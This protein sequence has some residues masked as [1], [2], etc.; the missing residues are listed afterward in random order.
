MQEVL[1]KETRRNMGSQKPWGVTGEGL[2]S[3]GVHVGNSGLYL[4]Q[5]E[6]MDVGK[7]RLAKMVM[8]R[9]CYLCPLTLGSRL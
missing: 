6:K 7:A 2:A 9:L 5:L 4:F 1:G 3:H 8:A